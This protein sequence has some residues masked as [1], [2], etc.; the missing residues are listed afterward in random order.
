MHF[1]STKKEENIPDPEVVKAKKQARNLATMRGLSMEVQVLQKQVEILSERCN[2]LE[3][4]FMTL[5]KKFQTFETQRVIELN[6]MVNGGPT[7]KE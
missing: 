5:D 3:G 1:G 4:V 2:R 7:V 6:R